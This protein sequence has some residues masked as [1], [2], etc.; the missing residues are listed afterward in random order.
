M[1]QLPPGINYS[2]YHSTSG[3]ST[4]DFGPSTWYFLFISIL[5]RYP[6][7][8]D[9]NNK[10][11]MK[12]AKAYYNLLSNLCMTLPCIF[13]RESYT[14]FLKEQ[15]LKPYL[16]GRIELFYWLYLMKDKVNKK[17]IEQENTLYKE[18]KNKL[19]LYYKNK[20]ITKE[21]Y[22]TK[23]SKL[24]KKCFYTKPTPSFD[25]ILNKYEAFRAKCNTKRKSCSK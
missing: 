12:I 5:G 25:V 9:K 17:L 10:E 21:Q 11:H 16:S 20:R 24:K 4:K 7:K 1:I 19:K 23:L 13:C 14:H 22:Y 3:M 6:I 8:I 15:P 18:Y 2:K